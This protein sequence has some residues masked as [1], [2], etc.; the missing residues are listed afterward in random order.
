MLAARH[1]HAAH[2]QPLARRTRRDQ[3]GRPHKILIPRRPPARQPRHN[4]PHMRQKSLP[5]LR[6]P[7]QH[8]RRIVDEPCWCNGRRNHAHG[9]KPVKTDVRSNPESFI[10]R[11]SPMNPKIEQEKAGNAKNGSLLPL[12]SPVQKILLKA[13]QSGTVLLCGIRGG[14]RCSQ[15]PPCCRRCR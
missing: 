2:M 9:A 12:L 7:R 13:K 15:N 1:Q 3:Q 6:N 10:Q 11:F 4:L 8:Q 5:R 14:G